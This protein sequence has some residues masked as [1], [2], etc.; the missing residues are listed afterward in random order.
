MVLFAILLINVQSYLAEAA[1]R[2]LISIIAAW[3]WVVQEHLATVP[4]FYCPPDTVP[5]AVIAD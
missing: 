4:A 1:L 2:A 3:I 5:A